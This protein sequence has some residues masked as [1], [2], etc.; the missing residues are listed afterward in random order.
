MIKIGEK[1]GDFLVKA[2]ISRGGMGNLYHAIDTMLNREVALKV[3]NPDLAGDPDFVR[4]FRTGAMA[5]AQMSHPNIITIFSLMK[6]DSHYLLAMEY[7]N[8]QSLRERLNRKMRIPLTEALGY[9]KQILRGLNYAHSRQIIHGDI[10]PENL[11]LDAR[12]QVKLSDFGIAK[13]AG[14]ATADSGGRI[15]GT[16]AYAS[17]EQ[18]LGQD[19]D[20]RSDLYSLGITFYEMA[21]GRV[22]F[23]SEKD[24]SFQMEE[25]HLHRPPPRPSVFNPGIQDEVDGFILKAIQKRPETRFQSAVEMLEQLDHLNPNKRGE[26]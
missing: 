1:V 4:K 14:S 8:G 2:E 25:A 9:L 20:A 21:T 16:A 18:I 23:E 22:P 5:Q 24:S 17:P 6:T 12:N 15:L 7:I 11:L 10:K 19:M 13:I 3:I 26:T